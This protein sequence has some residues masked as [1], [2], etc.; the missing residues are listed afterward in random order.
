MGRVMFI[1]FVTLDGVVQDPD[2]EDGSER[3]GW[4]FRYGPEAV[5]GDKFEVGDI[6]ET[7]VLLLG[8]VTWE[9]FSQLWPT[10][11]DE[12]STRMNRMSK[13]VASR[14]LERV[15]AWENSELVEAD[16]VDE[17]TR[18]KV[19]Q[20]IV[21]TGSASVVRLLQDHDLIDEYRLLV[22]PIVVGEGRRLFEHPSQ[23]VNL[24]LAKAEQVGA[25]LRVVY[26]RGTHS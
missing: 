16:L 26:A 4:A 8:R 5:A 21:V 15:D 3:G 2:G 23:S 14:S 22:F 25:A 9:K 13:L 12:F 24:R 7:G 18:R 6:M 17:V 11:D 10:R 1:G 20:D 19:E